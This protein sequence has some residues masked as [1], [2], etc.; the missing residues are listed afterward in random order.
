M[1]V[2]TL[3]I[4]MMFVPPLLV[5]LAIGFMTHRLRPAIRILAIVLSAALLLTPSFGPATIA[6]VPAPF[7]YLV[8]GAVLGDGWGAL[9]DLLIQY[10]I[11]HAVAFPATAFVAYLVSR[12]LRPNNSFKPKPLR[13]SA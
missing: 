6:V 4:L 5:V 7:G 3:I 13:G 9:M 11:W 10:P 8:L 2:M 12:R 1:I